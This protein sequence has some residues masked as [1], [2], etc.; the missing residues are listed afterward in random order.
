MDPH[1]DF[2]NL[3][4]TNHRDTSPVDHRYNCIAWSFGDTE[5][6]WQPGTY[7]R[8]VDWPV[9]DYG[10]GALERAFLLAGYEDCAA[11]ATLEPGYLKVALYA[12][13]VF[14]YTHA[15]RQLHTGQWTSKLGRSVDIEH[16]TPEVVAGGVYGE[17]MQIMKR[18]VG[19]PPVLLPSVSPA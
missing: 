14:L 9:N 15:A 3:T 18:A 7:W 19:A 11:D 2:P 16:D 4:P 6:W 1:P 10:L 12:A 5:H 8:P 17:V 13:S